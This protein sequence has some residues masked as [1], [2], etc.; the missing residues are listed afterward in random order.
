MKWENSIFYN[1][2]TTILWESNIKRIITM[3]F[4]GNYIFTRQ[5]LIF[6]DGFLRFYD[7]IKLHFTLDKS[8]KLLL[9]NL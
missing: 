2:N 9:L 8:V 7:V 1:N 6:Y 3:I 5:V 4:Y